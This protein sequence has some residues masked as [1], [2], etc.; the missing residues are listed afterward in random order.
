MGGA[1]LT[2]GIVVAV[3]AVCRR[4]QLEVLPNAYP[5]KQSCYSGPDCHRRRLR[6]LLRARKRRRGAASKGELEGNGGGCHAVVGIIAL[7]GGE[8][9]VK[10]VAKYFFIASL[11]RLGELLAY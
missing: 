6:L 4:W 5:Q 11:H 7:Y 3:L 2:F 9:R 1:P 10:R 8:P